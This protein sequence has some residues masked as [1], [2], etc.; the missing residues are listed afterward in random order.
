MATFAPTVLAMSAAFALAAN[1]A[2]TESA[3]PAAT[4]VTEQ[5]IV[6]RARNT[7]PGSGT[8]IDK[9]E[10]DRFDHVD[11][12]QVMS[13]LP[14]VYV[15]E[16]D[17]FGLRPNIGIRGAAAERSQKITLLADGVP[18]APAVYSAPAAYYMPN[19]GRMHAIEVLKGP[20][21]IH[22]GP[23]TVGGAINL[24]T[25]PVPTDRSAEL[26]VSLGNNGFH[27]FVAT[28]GDQGN[29]AGFLV[30]A[31][32][33]GSDGFKELDGGG[34]TGFVRNDLG[35]KLL[36]TP[37]SEHRFTL[38]VGY[39][40]EDSHENYLGVTDEDFLTSPYRRYAASALDRFSSE[41]VHAYFNHVFQAS[42]AFRV[43]AKAYWHRFERDWNK[44]EGL[45]SGRALQFVLARP[46]R[47]VGEYNLLTG[48]VDSLPTDAQTLDITNNSR[49]YS[50][51]GVQVTAA[52]SLVTG[53][54]GHRITG[55]VRLHRDDVE[56]NHMPRGYLMQS[57][58]LVFD[59][60]SRLPKLLN[61]AATQAIAVFA[62]EE[63][64]WGAATLTL[65]VR[66]ESIHGER[67]DMRPHR[68]FSEGAQEV[69]SPGVGLH[70]QLTEPLSILAGVYRG[71]SPAGPGSRD[72][73]PEQSVNYEYGF[74]YFTA[75]LDVEV[76]GFLSDYDNLLGRCRVSDAGCEPG[77]E[78]NAGR[79]E[80]SGLEVIAGAVHQL[81]DS[82]RLDADVVYTYTK[83]AFKTAFLSG[84]SQWGLVHEGDELPY[85]PTH[86][87]Q[88]R[89][90]LASGAWDLVAAFKHQSPMR[91][92]PGV[93]AVES[94][95]HADALT[96]LDV[97]GTWQ[98]RESTRAQVIVGNVTN[99]AAI[100]AHRPIGARPNRPRWITL[101]VQQSF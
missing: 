53:D 21:A 96:T 85:L 79:V 73:E 13:S 9:V 93:E 98:I 8:V 23:H 80:V 1:A 70:W 91:E 57:G 101:R 48:A 10:L 58:R 63:L 37:L 42:D 69:T 43:S 33:Y 78:F 30:E 68:P 99:E 47:F 86:R 3:N 46:S 11:V 61:R 4:E 71:F 97:T 36:W 77:D 62:S 7:V 89:L 12:N 19:I 55:G 35:V 2:A 6:I 26:D 87:A 34:P 90:G 52:L 72:A 92:E 18:V 50:T 41:H 5:I 22:Q 39:A 81:T 38:R 29:R 51:A 40:D 17:G 54:M 95:L 76:V 56:R 67:E 15:R 83:P 59:G 27:K 24:V 28:Y 25:P 60:L 64:T 32:R 45:F 44:L 14:G 16:E 66:H 88:F 20:S 49:S 75:P 100:V 31:L 84:F 94:G 65:G 82:I 74:R